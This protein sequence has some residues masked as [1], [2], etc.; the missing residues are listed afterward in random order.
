MS[1]NQTVTSADAQVNVSRSLT[2]LRP[3]FMSLD[4]TFTEARITWCSKS[5][6]TFYSTM[7]GDRDGP[8]NIKN[9]HNLIQ[10]LQLMIGSKMYPEFPIRSHAECFYNLRNSLCVQANS[11]HAVDI[12]GNEYL[13]NKFVVGFDTE[14]MLGLAFTGANAKNGLMTLKLKNS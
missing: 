4:K 12:K 2:S 13:R 9:T 10:H 5:W 6:N 7:L 8:S 14:R 1:S 3:V 11:L